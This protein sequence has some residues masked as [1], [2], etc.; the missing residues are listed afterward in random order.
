MEDLLTLLNVRLNSYLGNLPFSVCLLLCFLWGCLSVLFCPCH[1]ASVPMIISY[2]KEQKI[3]SVSYSAKLAFV[4]SFAILL[5]ILS[6]G[7]ITIGLGKIVEE[8]GKFLDYFIGAIFIVVGLHI[9][10]FIKYHHHDHCNEEHHDHHCGADEIKYSKK[11]FA[12]AFVWGLIFGLLMAPCTFAYMAPIMGAAL[13]KTADSYIHALLMFLFYGIG[14]IFVILL[15]CIFT[16][17][18]SEY[19][20]WSHDSKA[21]KIIKII[22][23][24]V[25]IIAGIHLFFE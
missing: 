16:Q 1:L 4:F 25:I 24:I 11:G 22:C 20:H 9:C 8:S 21:G 15:A 13:K 5:I 18:L 7:V 14:N 6:I 17:Y 2:I 12:G 3:M 10:G 23:G 19:N